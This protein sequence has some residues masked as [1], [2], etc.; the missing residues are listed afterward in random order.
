MLVKIMSAE[1]VPDDDPR[2]C[3]ELF[4]GVDAVAFNRCEDCGAAS[5]VMTFETGDV[6]AVEILGN[7]YILNEIGEPVSSFGVAPY[8]ETP[9]EVAL[10]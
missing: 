3:Y 8:V 1:N 4:S 5:V 9:E 2:K 6:L 7:V 10:H